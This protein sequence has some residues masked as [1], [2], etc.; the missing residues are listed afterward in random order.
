M[1]FIICLLLLRKHLNLL[2][3]T[4][5]ES[6]NVFRSIKV[7]VDNWDPIFLY[8]VTTKIAPS[9]RRAWA[10]WLSKDYPES[11]PK[12]EDI[13]EFLLGRLDTQIFS[14]ET[15]SDEKDHR[16]SRQQQQQSK[17]DKSKNTKSVNFANSKGGKNRDRPKCSFCKGTHFIGFCNKFSA[18]TISQRK[19][20]INTAQLCANCLN[21]GHYTN[22]CTSK[23][24]CLVCGQKHNTKIHSDATAA[25][26]SKSS[27]SQNSSAATVTR[28]DV[29]DSFCGSSISN[30][31]KILASA[32]I[33]L[34]GPN[35]E[36]ITVRAIID[37]GA[38]ESFVSERIVQALA[39]KKKSTH[40]LIKGVGCGTSAVA[41]SRVSMTLKSK[42]NFNFS[43]DFSALILKKVTPF[44][45]HQEVKLP[46]WKPFDSLQ[47]ADPDWN[48]P[49]RIDCLLDTEVYASIVREGIIA[50]PPGMH[51]VAINS[52]LGWLLLGAAQSDF[53]SVHTTT[54]RLAISDELSESLGKFWQIEEV[55]QTSLFSPEEEACYQHFKNTYFRDG[56]GRFVV[57]LPFKVPRPQLLETR[58]IAEA[59]FKRMERRC[60]RQ[61]EVA[62]K[63]ETFMEEYLS[64]H[65]MEE[66]PD[67]EV[68]SENSSYFP[69][70]A[71]FKNDGSRKIR[72][73]FNASQ[74][75]SNGVSLNSLLYAGP[76]LQEDVLAI[77]LRWAFFKFAF[78]CDIVK[79][80]RQFL[81]HEDDQD[82]QRILWRMTPEEI[83]RI[84]RLLTITYGTVSAPF[85]TGAC[86]LQLA[87][88]VKKTYPKAS[89]ILKKGRYVDNF[90]GGGDTPEEALQVRNQL[91]AALNSA[92]LP[93]DQWAA[94]HEMLLS[95]LHTNQG[96][97]DVSFSEQEAVS[98]LGLQWQAKED[99]YIF[100]ISKYSSDCSNPSTKRQILSDIAKLFDPIGWLS[101]VIIQAKIL[102]QDLWKMKAGWD[103]ALPEDKVKRWLDIRDQLG[104]LET[105]KIPRWLS[106]TKDSVFELHCFCDASEK[107][108]A[109]AIYAAIINNGV[110]KVTLITAK[111]KVAPINTISL[112]RLEL[113]G[114]L[115]LARLAVYVLEKLDRKPSKI[116]CW[117]DSEVVL[118]W[119]SSHPS[120]WK[121]FV[122]NRVSE[123]ITLLPNCHWRHVK[124]EDN[125]A[126]LPS[127]GLNPSQLKNSSLWWHGPE[128]L[129]R[130]E[131]GWYLDQEEF[132]TNLEERV[133]EQVVVCS[134]SADNW[135]EWVCK[136]SSLDKIIGILAYLRHAAYLLSLKWHL[137]LMSE[138]LC[139]SSS[140]SLTADQI[141]RARLILFKLVQR[142]AFAEE[143]SRLSEN[144]SVSHSSKI[145]RLAPFLD[146][147]GVLR[148]GGR[149]QN[150]F[151]AES[152]KHPIILPNDHHITTLLIRKMHLS[153]EHGGTT[154]VQSCLLRE[155]WI[156]K[157]RNRIRH[158]IRNCV[159][160]RRF[161][162]KTM[163]QMMGPLPA[164]RVRPSRAFTCTG[165]DFA[166]PFWIKASNLRGQR[167][168]KGYISLFICMVT[169][170]THIEVVSSLSTDAFLAAFRRFTSRRGLCHTMFSDNGTNFQGAAAEIKALQ[171]EVMN[172]SKEVAAIL[173]R[174]Q[175][176][177]LFIPPRAP[178]FGGLW[179]ASIKSFKS[180]LYRVI[181][182][183]KLSYE[184]FS[185]VATMIEACLNSRPLSP[186]NSNEEDVS[187]LTPGHF[188][189]GAALKSP[190]E[191]FDVTNEN[192]SS[193]SRWHK[194]QAM[195][196][197]F[198]SRWHKEFLSQLQ[199]RNKWLDPN[200]D[201]K[202]GDVVLFKDSLVPPTRWPLARITRLYPGKDELSRVAEIKTAVT[203][204]KRP[205]NKLIYLPTNP[206]AFS[207]WKSVEAAMSGG[208]ISSTKEVQIE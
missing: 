2:I 130:P 157:G 142:T 3:N 23:G 179:E 32:I 31:T 55:P 36:S 177:W 206:E 132:Q 78:T 64:L 187:A 1:H 190:P 196:N 28:A 9:T 50:G 180:Y 207:Y 19:E 152:E 11:F 6:L 127:R 7:P 195:R 144:Q 47:F 189:I 110:P 29:Q 34:Q 74:K 134:A 84:F 57:R 20:H 178:N 42:K 139:D 140:N 122:A 107:A 100:K 124:S 112:P 204:L 163:E 176:Q 86:M 69:H 95:D 4:I 40:V 15:T 148:V 51:L 56:E 76:K 133:A 197:H 137:K 82:W 5:N 136:F 21:S 114:A 48:K 143:I 93:L 155:F 79:M 73:V 200:R 175:V 52:V 17:K 159:K 25:A 126:D 94:N 115:T 92:K 188:L 67:A 129:T 164:V 191:P 26:V 205:I 120:R 185:T 161:G 101:P 193:L 171:E 158:I 149:L 169:K 97:Q 83:L 199:E 108:Y 30:S 89:H 14:N 102:I 154:L 77:L 33:I 146:K 62:K 167:A 39:L 38:E 66:V 208:K 165:V 46:E 123:I 60:Q 147:F 109:T 121:T 16:D 41:T 128:W 186:M 104:E 59:C 91:I 75:D 63:Y 150:A 10:K 183:V 68:N 103:D 156:V 118:A 173:A 141:A 45:P 98:A 172:M 96:H 105:I 72:V 43:I 85:Q 111:S 22:E 81:I 27:T 88:D 80:F 151:L 49:S 106:S 182:I 162:G 65:H 18:C 8:I 166:G 201:F 135:I 125:P 58:K 70:H 24:R 170:A 71:V 119:L 153:S 37:P 145:L 168:Y 61:P 181:G 13:Q 99:F 53:C 203:E 138:K 174:D 194:L 116:H 87:N 44:T 90:F 113:C 160:C 198:W 184:E 54:V 202:V 35:G 131:S 117:S 12:L 192:I